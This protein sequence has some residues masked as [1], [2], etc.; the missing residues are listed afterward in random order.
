MSNKWEDFIDNLIDN[1]GK[2]AKDDLKNLIKSAENDS[3]EFINAQGVKMER[4]LTQ[5]A[6]NA[7]TKDEFEG[8][9][10]DIKNLTEMQALKMSVA[11]KAKAQS[12]VN[13]I[14]NLIINGL[15]KLI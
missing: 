3:E 10:L 4:Y 1:S 15:L 2:L 7:I 9:I 5:L 8:Y 11:G 6:T 14:S 13:G 12:L